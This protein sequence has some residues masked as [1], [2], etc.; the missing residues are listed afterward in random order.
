MKISLKFDAY[1]EQKLSKPW[2]ALITA[3][4]SDSTPAIKWGTYTGD[5][6]GG[7]AEIEAKAG[8]IV[9]WGQKQLH[10]KRVPSHWG[11]VGEDGSIVECTATGARQ[12]WEQQ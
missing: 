4:P 6:T 9:R 10:D 7:V 1:N 2:I 3:W 5:H 11:I 8:D 12:A